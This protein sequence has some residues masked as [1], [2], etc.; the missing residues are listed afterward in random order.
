MLE[1]TLRDYGDA[2]ILPK[3]TIPV[4]KIAVA[5]V[6][7]NNSNIKV[8]FESCASSKW[9]NCIKQYASR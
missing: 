1:T 2:F 4:A 5:V 3:K 7:A 9:N 8:I 6:A